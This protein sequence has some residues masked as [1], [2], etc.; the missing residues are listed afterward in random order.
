MPAIQETLRTYPAIFPAEELDKLDYKAAF[1]PSPGKLI[2]L[3]EALAGIGITNDTAGWRNL[4]QVDALSPEARDV[5]QKQIRDRILADRLISIDRGVLQGHIDDYKS[6]I[7]DGWKVVVV[8]HSQ[9]NFFAN[10]ARA[11]L[12]DTEKQA[13]AIVAVA[14][15][16]N[17]VEGRTPPDAFHVTLFEDNVIELVRQLGLITPLGPTLHTSSPEPTTT[18]HMFVDSYLY[19]LSSSEVTIAIYIR[20]TIQALTNPNCVA[21]PPAATSYRITDLY[22]QGGEVPF[23]EGSA[24]NNL[25]QVVGD[26]LTAGTPSLAHALFLNPG[27]APIDLG[28]LPGAASSESRAEGVNETDVVLLTHGKLRPLGHAIVDKL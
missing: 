21:S 20:Q 7:R 19:P 23:L 1:N 5:I 6:Y 15:P 17:H 18:G 27:Q 9:G 2:D 10:E 14:T 4:L 12:S 25:G 26:G 16:D 13:L 8:S 11:S 24:I 22:A 28:V 3:L